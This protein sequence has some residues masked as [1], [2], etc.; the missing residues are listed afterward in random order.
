MS[1]EVAQLPTRPAIERAWDR[2]VALIDAVRRNDALRTDLAHQQAIATAWEHWR[3]L[4]LAG[5]R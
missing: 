1:A 2:Y 4:F 3:D 5:A